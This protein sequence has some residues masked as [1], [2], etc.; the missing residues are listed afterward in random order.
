V[1]RVSDSPAVAL[2]R[3][4]W[5]NVDGG[6][7]KSWRRLNAAMGAATRL[8]VSAGLL[9]HLEDWS[10]IYRD[11]RGQS[12]LDAEHM[13]TIAVEEGNI[14][15]A[16]AW[17]ARQ[18]RAP[19]LI[20]RCRVA[21]G[22]WF[23]WDGNHVKVSSFSVTGDCIVACAYTNNDNQRTPTKRYKLTLKDLKILSA[24]ALL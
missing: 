15:A 9:F 14:S 7:T 1:T 12:W 10:T 5:H 23:I 22:T 13:Y 6:K 2:I 20:G 24:D 18:K 19:F 17:E 21:V 16:K 3:H 4:V 11:F 8:A